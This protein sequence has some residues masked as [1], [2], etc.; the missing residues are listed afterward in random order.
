MG[1][2][3]PRSAR[4]LLLGGRPAARDVTL[5]A[6]LLPDGSVLQG[7]E[8]YTR[9]RFIWSPS[10]LTTDDLEAHAETAK[11]R[12]TLAERVS[13]PVRPA[14][15]V[16]DVFI[17]GGGPAG[18]TAALYA[19]SEGLRTLVVEV[20][21][22]G[23]QAATSSKIENYPGFPQGISGHEL[24]E[25]TYKQAV[26]LG[27]EIL[28]GIEIMHAVPGPPGDDAR[29]HVELSSGATLRA[30]T[31]VASMG[32]HYRRLE[33]PGVEE[34]VGAGIFYG[35]APSEA[36]LFRDAHVVVVGGANSAG[37]AALHLSEFART[38]TMV[39]RADALAAAMSDYLV[40]RI[41]AHERIDVRTRSRIIA[42]HGE[43]RLETLV[44][45]DDRTDTEVEVEVD[46]AFI[47]IGAQPLTAGVEGWLR[48]DERGFLMTGPD[49]LTD[50]DRSWWPLDRVPLFLESSEP[51]VFAADVRHGSIKRV[52]SAVG[53]GA[54]AT[55]LIHRYLNASSVIAHENP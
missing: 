5:P 37:Q 2:P 27:A 54:M 43:A 47:L 42:A 44:L 31:G 36:P 52:A 41:E 9:P 33:A 23:G 16:Y 51:G 53:E 17:V 19:A 1:R 21:A 49:L 38:V 46:A 4:R 15:D 3:R 25:S 35:S 6:A 45:A 8:R 20:N 40:Q 28:V 11:W 48:R 30:R 14:H 50:A 29:L 34:L 39:V 26:R 10:E 24:A 32:V 55:A 12:A 7:P 18:L 13:L 22:P